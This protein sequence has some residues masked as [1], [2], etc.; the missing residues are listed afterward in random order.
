MEPRITTELQDTLKQHPRIETVYFEVKTGLHHFNHVKTDNNGTLSVNGKTVIA[1]SSK[2]VL[3]KKALSSTAA[4]QAA[5]NSQAIADNL[6]TLINQAS[7]K[8]TK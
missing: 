6:L 8:A 4:E 3:N 5:I 1:M 2:E 7:A